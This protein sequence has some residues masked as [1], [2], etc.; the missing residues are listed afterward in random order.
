MTPDRSSDRPG[1][2]RG[3]FLA[4]TGMGPAAC[5]EGVGIDISASTHQRINR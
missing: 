5:T 3:S 1:I 4:D 2:T